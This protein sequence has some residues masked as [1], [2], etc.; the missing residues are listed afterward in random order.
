ML[1]PRAGFLPVHCRK[2]LAR[3][4]LGCIA[5]NGQSWRVDYCRLSMADL[6]LPTL[7]PTP[8]GAIP[9]PLGCRELR[10]PPLPE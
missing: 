10:P 8:G 9:A 4:F 2:R 6:H 3:W 5:G 1:L 7:D